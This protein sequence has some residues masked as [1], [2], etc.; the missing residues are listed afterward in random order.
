MNI[1]MFISLYPNKWWVLLCKN[2]CDLIV[3]RWHLCLFFIIFI[4][5]EIFKKLFKINSLYLLFCKLFLF[6]ISYRLQEKLL[7]TYFQSLKK[8]CDYLSRVSDKTSI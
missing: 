8:L 1:C 3:K 5:T 4:I 6:A 7:W 2:I